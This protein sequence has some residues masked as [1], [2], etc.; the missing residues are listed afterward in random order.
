MVLGRYYISSLRSSRC[1][2]MTAMAFNPI[3]FDWIY[4]LLDDV[5]LSS[6]LSFFPTTNRYG[7]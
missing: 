1:A 2:A 4:G 6:I 7:S 5:P 3:D